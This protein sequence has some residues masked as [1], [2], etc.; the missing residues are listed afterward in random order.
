MTFILKYRELVVI[1]VLVLTNGLTLWLYTG[2]AKEY[3]SF[4]GGVAAYAKA[5][6]EHNA[7]LRKKSAKI[8]EDTT[9]GWKAAVDYLRARPVGVLQRACASQMP[10]VSGP[11]AGANE[12]GQGP[13]LTPARIEEDASSDILKLNHLQDWLQRQKALR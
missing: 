1:A 12:A 7:E 5:Q 4:R 6:E 3:S 2:T 11:A 8:T 10:G 9:N 13:I